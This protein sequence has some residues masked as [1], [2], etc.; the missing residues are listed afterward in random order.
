MLQCHIPSVF[1]PLA[2]ISAC[3]VGPAAG[4][5]AGTEGTGGALVVVFVE[6]FVGYLRAAEPATA[7]VFEAEEPICWDW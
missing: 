5:C 4:A 3:T 6:A 7:A 2:C 1:V